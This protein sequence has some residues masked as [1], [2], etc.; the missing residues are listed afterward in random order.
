[1]AVRI[2]ILQRIT[3]R[4]Q[5]AIVVDDHPLVG[6][7]RIRRDERAKC[8]IIV[9]RIV[10]QQPR[11]ISLLSGKRPV[12]LQS[13]RRAALLAVDVVRA[14]ALHDR[15]RRRQRRTAEMV[16]VQMVEDADALDSK[17]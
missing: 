13:S 2:H 5:E 3:A 4:I 9:A 1:M 15:T 17:G 8:G 10:V 12:R 6:H 16:A 14:A 7:N 11:P